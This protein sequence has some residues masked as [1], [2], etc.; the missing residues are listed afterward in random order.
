[1]KQRVN[2]QSCVSFSLTTIELE[3]GPLFPPSQWK[4]QNYTNI[5]IIIKPRPNNK[6]TTMKT[7]E[8]HVQEMSCFIRRK[9]IKMQVYFETCCTSSMLP[10]LFCFS[11]LDKNVFNFISW[12]NSDSGRNSIDMIFPNLPYAWGTFPAP[13]E[14]LSESD[15]SQAH[16]DVTYPH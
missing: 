12:F 10:L 13:Q 6:K 16:D 14:H 4:N 7:I 1:M 8:F 5:K 3:F 9:L 2:F 15:T 11:L